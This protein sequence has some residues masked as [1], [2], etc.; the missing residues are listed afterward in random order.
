MRG[1]L[2]VLVLAAAVLGTAAWFG[3]PIVASSLISGALQNAGYRA[4]SS[5][6][7]ATSSPPLKLVIGRADQV[8][9]AGTD[10]AF[11]TFH[12][13]SADLVLTDVDVFNRSAGHISGRIAGA[14]MTTTAGD[15][16]GADI[17][18]DGAAGAA[19]AAIVVD[20]A[21]V[22]RLVKATLLQ[23]FGYAVTT[24]Q[25][26]APDI[27]RIAAPGVTVEGRLLVDSSGAIAFSTSLGSS[28]I[29]SLDPSFPLQLRSVRIEAGNLRI[30]AVLDANA[31]L[32]G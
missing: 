31:L 24:A 32:S 5:T 25:L 21:T 9:I 28:P 11:R 15:P 2:F 6:V 20:A 1:C 8:E 17:A 3:S 12:A 10:V 27:L 22:S 7:T 14:E 18:I 26:V 23:K 4:A 29:L 19:D 30:D 16:T 13:A